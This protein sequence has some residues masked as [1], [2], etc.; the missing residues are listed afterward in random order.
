MGFDNE[1]VVFHSGYNDLEDVPSSFSDNVT[2][3]CSRN[4]DITEILNI[5]VVKNLFGIK[6]YLS[7]IKGI[8]TRRKSSLMF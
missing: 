1:S 4:T 2:R 5:F 8:T 6:I 3:K 7:F